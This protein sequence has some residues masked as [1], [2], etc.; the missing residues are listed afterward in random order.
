M[1]KRSG[2]YLYCFSPL[3]MMTTFLI[4]F[5][6][7]LYILYRYRMDTNARLITTMLGCLAIFQFAEYMICQSAFF[8][9]SLDWAKIGY[10]AITILP[11][12]GIH[13]GLTI[14]KQKNTQILAAAYGS[15]GL[16]MSYFL[17]IGQG[18]QASKCLGNYVIFDI[19]SNAVLP[20]GVFYYGWLF[21][22]MYLF[23]NYKDQIVSTE[24]KQALTWLTY[25][26]LSFL[27]PSTVVTLLDPS[28]MRAVPSVM[29]GFAVLMALC[30][31]FKV[32]PLVL[33]DS[34]S[35]PRPVPTR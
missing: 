11:P 17:F 12:L 32:A 9:S 21:T 35:Q 10:M 30:L 23:W 24:R 15:A 31:L 6:S 28:T 22:G 5:G 2:F 29:C 19:A 34:N 4:E 33:K 27:V 20:Y 8:L 25:G 13:L 14:A 7:A 18:I 26:Y 16:F 1:N 3:V